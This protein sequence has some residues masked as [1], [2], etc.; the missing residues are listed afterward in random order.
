MKIESIKVAKGFQYSDAPQRSPEWIAIRAPRV[1]SSDLYRWMAVSKR[2]GKTPLKAR[3]DV[4]RELAFAK[5]FNIPFSKF[6]HAAM[7]EGIDNEDFLA[8]Q[9]A[10]VKKVELIKVG[11]AYNDVFVASPD[12][13]IK[14]E[15]GGVE[16]KW[17]YD[18]VWSEVVANNKPIDD[19]Y[20][21]MQGQMWA[22]G[23]EF[24]DYVAGDGN[25]GRFIVIRVKRD[26]ALI[27]EIM[28][29]V[30][31]VKDVKPMSTKNV[32]EFNAGV[33]ETVKD[34]GVN[35]WQSSN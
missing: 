28:E 18:T 1:G 19:H 26:Q 15:N 9:Y 27:K 16:L 10:Q 33:P 5:T 20:K 8:D 24:V 6:T 13:A 32:Y 2:D 31:A 29:S 23:W 3:Q 7:Q 34:T 12:R 4:E 25:T 14:G 21:Q 22:F 17:L 11:C 30:K 35:P